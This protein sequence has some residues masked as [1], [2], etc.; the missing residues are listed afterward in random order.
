[1]QAPPS[2]K[3][4]KQQE[5]CAK[6]SGAKGGKGGKSQEIL[7]YP[8]S[9]QGKIIGPAGANIQ[10]IRKKSGAIIIV[11]QPDA[12]QSVTQVRITGSAEEVQMARS[13]VEAIAGGQ[14]L[15]SN[16]AKPEKKNTHQH[17]GPDADEEWME[18]PRGVVPGLIGKTGETITRLRKDS[19]AKIDVNN[20]AE[21]P[22]VNISGTYEAVDK[23]RGMVFDIL[24]IF[25]EMG[26]VEWPEWTDE[27]FLKLPHKSYQRLTDANIKRIEKDSWA[28]VNV[29]EAGNW[30]EKFMVHVLG[31]PEAV[32][33]A[34]KLIKEELAKTNTRQPWTKKEDWSG[35]DQQWSNND[36][37]RKWTGGDDWK[38]GGDEKQWSSDQWWE[39]DT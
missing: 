11:E 3:G 34:R 23:A 37:K 28:T 27:D 22:T 8:S 29:E 18:V 5:G 16:A 10:D 9:F 36:R 2:F 39:A 13:L 21:P 31:P 20:M 6:G 35:D 26:K 32:S 17:E 12:H 1:M 15:S 24:K 14:P 33:E 38:D 7:Q 30:Q 4:G 25:H 19:G